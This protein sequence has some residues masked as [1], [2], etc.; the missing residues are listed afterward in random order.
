VNAPGL[1]DSGYR[2][3]IKVIAINLDPFEAF[4]VRRGD[5]IAQLVIYPVPATTWRPVE[6][7]PAS[8]RGESG[9]GSTGR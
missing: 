5:K 6:E 8:D 1:I 7:L 9:F 2:G 4:E 3:E